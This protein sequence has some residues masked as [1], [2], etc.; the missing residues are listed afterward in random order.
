M[1]EMEWN[2][3]GVQKQYK[4]SPISAS[5]LNPTSREEENKKQVE[6][7]YYQFQ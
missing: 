1:K 5:Q 7:T 2:E 6:Q 3:L 4:C